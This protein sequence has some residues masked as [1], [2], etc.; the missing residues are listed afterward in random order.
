MAYWLTKLVL[1]PILHLLYRIRVEGRENVPA[2]GPAILASNHVAFCDSMF[3]PL[4]LRRRLTYVAKAEYFDNW[5]TAWYFR[6]IGMIPIRRGPG[7]DW[8]RALDAAV[9]VLAAGRLFGIYPEGT[10]SKD[11]RLHRGHTGVA[12]VALETGAPVIPVGLVGTRAVQ[13]VGARMIRP[14]KPVTIRIGTPLD[15]SAYRGRDNERMV[16]RYITD[17]VMC[18]IQRLSGQEYAGFYAPIGGAAFAGQPRGLDMTVPADGSVCD[19]LPTEAEEAGVPADG[20]PAG[21]APGA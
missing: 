8:R 12:R 16:L 20:P 17:T 13:P 6:A 9:E 1:W 2:R 4:V 15:F 14:F 19:L 18:E 11:G 3:L 10:R 5:K 7:A 21:A